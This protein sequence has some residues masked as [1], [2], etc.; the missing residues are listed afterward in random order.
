[1]R[2]VCLQLAPVVCLDHSGYHSGRLL[3]VTRRYTWP[4]V[5]CHR[6]RCWYW[7]SAAS[8]PHH[9]LPFWTRNQNHGQHWGWL[10]VT[11]M[12]DQ[13]Y[14][15][16]TLVIIQTAVSCCRRYHRCLFGHHCDVS[17]KSQH[18][19]K[20]QVATYRPIVVDLHMLKWSNIIANNIRGNYRYSLDRITTIEMIVEMLTCKWQLI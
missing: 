11:P 3:G 9:H 7:P 10:C 18:L 16:L 8:A 15:V 5:D 14:T 12:E 1:M 19:A 4:H 20:R 2:F 17:H 6:S 13:L